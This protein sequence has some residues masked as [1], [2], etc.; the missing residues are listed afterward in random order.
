MLRQP[1]S[2]PR[3]AFRS[4]A[5]APRTSRRPTSSTPPR[6]RSNRG[7]RGRVRQPEGRVGPGRLPPG[8][9]TAAVHTANGCFRKVN[10]RGGATP[11]PPIRAGAS[12]SRSTSKPSR[13]RAPD[14]RS[15]WSR[16]TTP[17]SR[18]REVREHGGAPGRR[19]RVELLR[20]RRVQRDPRPGR[21]RTTPTP[22]SPRSRPR[23]TSG[24]GARPVPG[25]VGRD[26]RRS[27]ERGSRSHTGRG[28][29]GRGPAP[30]A[31]ARRGSPSPPGSTTAIVGCE[32]WQTS[33]PSRTPTPDSRSMTPSGWVRTT[34]GSRSAG[35]ACPPPSSRA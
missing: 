7:D 8:V 33:P 22:A 10:Q 25:G 15:C 26:D 29:S 20:R 13:P 3:S 21:P 19:Y 17:H 5:T 1:R 11:P 27:A 16:P 30:A 31:G 4:L 18:H 23:V 9:G 12:R 14:A 6:L 34:A 28:M 2:R 32:R 35:P 24:F